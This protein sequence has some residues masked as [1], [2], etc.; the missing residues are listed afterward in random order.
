LTPSVFKVQLSRSGYA[1]F[2]CHFQNPCL[3]NIIAAKSNYIHHVAAANEKK[4][5]LSL[6][7]I[8]SVVKKDT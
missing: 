2:I 1:S 7:H 6:L 3:F 5:S 8:K 4:N